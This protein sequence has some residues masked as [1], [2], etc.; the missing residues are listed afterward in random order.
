MLAAVLNGKAARVTVDGKDVGWREL[1]RQRED[2]ITAAFFGR[3]THLSSPMRAEA[4]KL[5]IGPSAEGLGDVEEIMFW[6]T[7]KLGQDNE[8][9]KVE[10]DIVIICENGLVMVEVKPPWGQQYEAQ[11][12]NE[13][14]ALLETIRSKDN[15][16]FSDVKEV[17]F[18]ALGQNSGLD[19]Q[20]SFANFDPGEFFDF[21]PHQKEWPD[22]LKGIDGWVELVESNDRAVVSDWRSIFDLFGVRRPIRPFPDLSRLPRISDQTLSLLAKMSAGAPEKH[23]ADGSLPQKWPPLIYLSREFIM[24]DSQC[25]SLLKKLVH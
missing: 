22:L 2:L 11:W 24:E 5:L 8:V 13:V 10:P 7:L 16:D 14:N 15:K 20:K 17:H 9:R 21:E 18:L 19:I 4:L 12:H 1:F 6:P 25:K 23:D 3:L